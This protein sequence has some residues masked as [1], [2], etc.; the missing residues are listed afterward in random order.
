[1]TA[2]ANSEGAFLGTFQEFPTQNEDEL[3]RV[4]TRMYTGLAT[5]VNDRELAYYELFEIL[6]GNRYWASPYDA[7]KKRFSYR[8]CFE[9]P[10]V[11]TNATLTLPHGLSVGYFTKIYGVLRTSIAGTVNWEP[12]PYV[13]VGATDFVSVRCTNVNIIIR[14]GAGHS[15]ISEGFLVLEYLKA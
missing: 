13:G 4:L 7:Q 6:T 11:A 5:G 12:I 3:K 8:K 9:L 14:V 15:G 10:S 1:M 2:P